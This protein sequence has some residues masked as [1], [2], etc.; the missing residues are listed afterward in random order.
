MILRKKNGVWHGVQLT[1]RCAIRFAD[2]PAPGKESS[3]AKV[4]YVLA[5]K[6]VEIEGAPK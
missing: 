4:M 5:A 2:Y 6:Y 1:K 3:A